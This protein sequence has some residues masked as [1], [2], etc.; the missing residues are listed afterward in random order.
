M[1]KPVKWTLDNI[2]QGLDDYQKAYGRYPSALEIDK[3]DL[4]P[5][6]RQIQRKFGGL[7]KLREPLGLL[8]LDY[9]KGEI[10]SDSARK[11][12]ERGVDSEKL[13]YEL[14]LSKFGEMFVHA[15]KPFPNYK[16]RFDYFVYTK[17]YKF[18][19]DVFFADESHSFAGCVNTKQRVYKNISSD[20][21]LL[22]VNDFFNQEAIDKFVKNKTNQLARNIKVM[23]LEGFKNFLSRLEPIILN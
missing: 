11:T 4:L 16:G 23:T 17:G 6:S 8:D 5:S 2:R 10:R 20:V 1:A 18:G 12:W 14:L 19:V 21:I 13:I 7:V 3:F 15:Q 22:S 9:T